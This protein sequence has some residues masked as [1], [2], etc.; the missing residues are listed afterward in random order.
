M[1]SQSGQLLQPEPEPE[2]E[3]EP[4]PPQP[5]H[6][7]A[8]SL[9][10]RLAPA[11][12]G[13]T[14]DEGTPPLRPADVQR[15]F[16]ALVGEPFDF[17]SPYEIRDAE[18]ERLRE[19][20]VAM[21][22]STGAS[23]RR[24]LESVQHLAS[25][26][27]HVD[28]M[29]NLHYMCEA[30]IVQA[31]V[32]LCDEQHRRGSDDAL[33]T[34]A[35][36]CLSALGRHSM[37]R[38]ALRWLMR[39][40][41]RSDSDFT[42]DHRQGASLLLL[43]LREVVE[44]DGPATFVDLRDPLPTS[45]RAGGGKSEGA[46]AAPGGVRMAPLDGTW[47]T[48]GYSVL[49]WMR[50]EE[51]TQDAV[52]PRAVVRFCSTDGTTGWALRM[53]ERRL[54]L[55]FTAST[56]GSR[57]KKAMQTLEL[58]H[59][60]MP[61]GEWLHVALV[62]RRHKL[63]KST[64][65]LYVN[66]ELQIAGAAG[67]AGGSA[68][69]VSGSSSDDGGM[70]MPY[71]EVAG[72][73]TQCHIGNLKA[74]GNRWDVPMSFCGQLGPVIL[75]G[76]EGFDHQAKAAL[77]AELYQ[78]G[79]DSFLWLD[80]A[81]SRCDFTLPEGSRRASQ[82]L[83]LDVCHAFIP[84]A[85]L[86]MDLEESTSSSS[87]STTELA[88]I[89]NSA[90]V[91]RAS[92]HN[93]GDD[94]PSG[95]GLLRPSLSPEDHRRSL[96][97]RACF[98][99]SSAFKLSLG[100]L[101]GP[102]LVIPF[103]GTHQSEQDVSLLFRLLVELFV[104]DETYRQ[105]MLGCQ[106]FTM[107]A[108]LLSQTHLVHL[109]A[110]V[111]D[112]IRAVSDALPA[113]S[114]PWADLQLHLIWHFPLWVYAPEEYQTKL[115]ELLSRWTSDELGA[116][117]FR[118]LI[119][120]QRILDMIRL[121]YWDEHNPGIR[122]RMPEERKLP[123]SVLSIYLTAS[124]RAARTSGRVNVRPSR[125]VLA[126]MR[127]RL[128]C[129]V[130]NIVGTTP[131]F[132]EVQA[133]VSFAM[134][135]PDPIPVFE[136]VEMIIRLYT[137]PA[138]TA[139]MVS[140]IE[141][142][143]GA[144]LCLSGFD[145][146]HPVVDAAFMRL[147]SV[148]LTTAPSKKVKP[149]DIE[150]LMLAATSQIEGRPQAE[151]AIDVMIQLLFLQVSSPS[152]VYSDY[153]S[154]TSGKLRF[155]R[156]FLTDRPTIRFPAL[157]DCVLRA[158]ALCEDGVR[159]R[160]VL[161]LTRIIIDDGFC[162]LMNK[163]G[164]QQSLIEVACS[165]R[166]A[167]AS[168]DNQS[169]VATITAV[170]HLFRKALL[171]SF[172]DDDGHKVWQE[173]L[174]LIRQA[175]AN[176]QMC[177]VL[178][179]QQIIY[180]GMLVNLQSE[181]GTATVKSEQD[182]DALWENVSHF[183]A[184]EEDWY[185]LGGSVGAASAF[186]TE[187]DLLSCDFVDLYS[188]FLFAV[189]DKFRAAISCLDLP[190][191]SHGGQTLFDVLLAQMLT[192]FRHKPSADMLMSIIPLF[193]LNLPQSSCMTPRRLIFAVVQLLDCLQ[194]AKSDVDLQDWKEAL[195]Q[196]IAD[197][198]Q[199]RWDELVDDSGE[200]LLGDQTV[201][202]PR[203]AS[204]EVDEF[205]TLLFGESW[206][207]HLDQMRRLAQE[208]KAT[209]T[210]RTE[211]QVSRIFGAAAVSALEEQVGKHRIEESSTSNSLITASRSISKKLDRDETNR[212]TA[213][214][215][216]IHQRK[217]A[218]AHHLLVDLLHELCTGPGAYAPSE[219]SSHTTER[220]QLRWKID[221][222][223]LNRG[224]R[225]RMRLCH[226]ANGR[227]YRTD[228]DS[229]Q[230]QT[231][232]AGS[233]INTGTSPV[234]TPQPMDLTA[235]ESSTTDVESSMSDD[236]CSAFLREADKH[237]SHA[238]VVQPDRFGAGE[239]SIAQE[240]DEVWENQRSGFSSGF[241]HEHLLPVERGPWTDGRGLRQLPKDDWDCVEG[242]E[243]ATEWMV[244]HSDKN[245]EDGWSY[246]QSF[247]APRGWRQSRSRMSRVRRR[248]WVRLRKRIG[249]GQ[250]LG[251]VRYSGRSSATSARVSQ[252]ELQSVLTEQLFEAAKTSVGSSAE[253]A[254][255]EILGLASALEFDT[256]MLHESL[257][258]FDNDPAQTASYLQELADKKRE[259][260]RLERRGSIQPE[261]AA[262]ASLDD[263]IK[264]SLVA[265]LTELLH[266][267]HGGSTDEEQD[268][269]RQ[270]VKQQFGLG[271][272]QI[273]ECMSYM[274]HIFGQQTDLATATSR[275]SHISQQHPSEAAS[276]GA[277]DLVQDEEWDNQVSNADLSVLQ[278][279][280]DDSQAYNEE[281]PEIVFGC[282]W[283]TPTKEVMGS[284]S[285]TGR[286][287]YFSPFDLNEEK[288]QRW[289][290]SSLQLMNRRRYLM[291]HTALEF[292]LSDGTNALLD[293]PMPGDNIQ[294]SE[295]IRAKKPP[296]LDRKACTFSS[297]DVARRVRELSGQW[298]AGNIDNFNYLMALN[299]LAGR[300]YSDLTQYPVMPWVLA[301]YTSQ[302]LDLSNPE[303]FRDLS[304]PM[305][306]LSSERL[307]K[308][309]QRADS[310]EDDS[311]P[312]FLFGT[313]YS[314]KAAT[315]HYLVRLEPFTSMHVR[316]QSGKFDSADRMFHSIPMT[317]DSCTS[318]EN[319]S[320]VKE[321][322]PEWFYCPEMFR[323]DANLPLGTRSDGAALADVI[324]PPWADTPEDFVRMHREALESPH[325]SSQLHNWIDLIFGVKQNGEAAKA[326]DNV[327]FHLTYE[328]AVTVDPMGGMD[329]IQQEA[330]KT[331]LSSFGQTPTQLFQKPHLQ[332]RPHSPLPPLQLVPGD[333]IPLPLA[334]KTDPLPAVVA[335]GTVSERDEDILYTLH[336][337]NEL[338][339]VRVPVVTS[340]MGGSSSSRGDK[341][342][343]QLSVFR[344]RLPLAGDRQRWVVPSPRTAAFAHDCR[345]LLLGCAWDCSL[346]IFRVSRSADSV[347]LAS[348]VYHRSAISCIGLSE[349]EEVLLLGSRDSNVTQWRLRMPSSSAGGGS[350]SGGGSSGGG[351]G[352]SSG[353][354][355]SLS[356][357]SSSSSSSSTGG[358]GSLGLERP[359]FVYSEHS[360]EVTAVACNV[361]LD[362]IASAS[363]DGMI[364]LR[365][366]RTGNYIRTI[367]HDQHSPQALHVPT[368]AS[369]AAGGADG[370]F[371]EPVYSCSFTELAITAKNGSIIS[372]FE[373]CYPGGVESE[374]LLHS[375]NGR[376]LHRVAVDAPSS[377]PVRLNGAAAGG[378]G[379]LAWAAGRLT[380]LLLCIEGSEIVVR[381][382][383]E[384]PL[385]DLVRFQAQ[386]QPAAAAASGG[387]VGGTNGPSG[388]VGVSVAVADGG[389]V[390]VGLS[391]GTVLRQTLNGIIPRILRRRAA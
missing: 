176:D 252:A 46:A 387:I 277:A 376:L 84:Q 367:K 16:D 309:R 220:D 115:L 103:F 7:P 239:D 200:P 256:T 11:A 229:T 190:A 227:S 123:S 154:I 129:V 109:G 78:Q 97:G 128:L 235:G 30:G 238:L 326:A 9:S 42:P 21:A 145:R 349:R 94:S 302:S 24:I 258:A 121:C 298:E 62:H 108:Q 15:L 1:D 150:A 370:S 345:L 265:S 172:Q 170:A 164:W 293:F 5:E 12:G 137:S 374:L 50:L 47:P 132:L 173:T 101:G 269:C 224:S 125:P 210:F 279:T 365:S 141:K 319:L 6:T 230:E 352:G 58:S 201:M 185:A 136:V 276:D 70:P 152:D 174:V 192:A 257:A 193:Q 33:A 333:G 202:L 331:Q 162:A 191:L 281:V 118:K 268:T 31:L 342:R 27:N 19:L 104:S 38:D 183:L 248:R 151:A 112:S 353:G 356:S 99:Q 274:A 263:S 254:V 29:R 386:T 364:V 43:V 297:Q 295:L 134:E 48:D 73:I 231:L 300:T 36:A 214:L 23:L 130:E 138:T 10:L 225:M 127:H 89:R 68:A 189:A 160:A 253:D 80:P 77:L 140:Y 335:I 301:D 53:I 59:W 65:S 337:S 66:G 226:N 204:A 259:S 328:G 339:I 233:P 139:L 156:E 209:G 55:S 17:R 155:S 363:A 74:P 280:R 13:G 282:Q 25:G 381:D 119:G 355:V 205:C 384:R 343:Q 110:K 289:P 375:I 113:D 54:H 243:W 272:E 96:I 181:I 20:P 242:W 244:E 131:S 45:Q 60:T 44:K 234:V 158:A 310:L 308:F 334:K 57:G 359:E 292:F 64:V 102:R 305:G 303:T 4:R 195:V 250:E 291:Q 215:P 390:Y 85:Y 208:T 18:R 180:R 369:A 324:L 322:T 14:L 216:R 117:R 325:V 135:C 81:E 56:M 312:W 251:P 270:A 388:V 262:L 347:L 283:I 236:F 321:L 206:K 49:L 197:V 120:V 22:Q 323:N 126:Q 313:H 95:R 149:A 169:I 203:A 286:A 187:A 67:I 194:S 290:F 275:E 327:F 373:S 63:R 296:N 61:V 218:K 287:M 264:S 366:V 219:V 382:L 358:Y 246:A 288:E 368:T 284:F 307:E 237:T 389:H 318:A 315:L 188:G 249:S 90:V 299:T 28:H 228:S 93:L 383:H 330:I 8:P 240:V 41:V 314:T 186:A 51:P 114:L 357:S 142:L 184:D 86:M 207:P 316:M 165:P 377:Q 122:M 178:P 247:P 222:T 336:A 285:L 157:L 105:T 348:I 329:P 40:V 260:V 362:T 143:G 88:Q 82:L 148:I 221:P 107:I 171:F 379:A 32:T 76:G 182:V 372:V 52:A 344:Q 111:V 378:G 106:A 317:W 255:A 161:D 380:E 75:C 212:V 147:L 320:N 304:K 340:S 361:D 223:E 294:V 133:M 354:G 213:E 245:D 26:N 306:A 179:F 35:L 39:L 338:R 341:K 167:G 153:E 198:L 351:G 211:E 350:G 332:R 3:L 177:F 163:S 146:Q 71:P 266:L 261:P 92:G 271:D 87:E 100:C 273:D 69:S 98:L 83:P 2:P 311:V 79:P 385:H 241:S 371:G 159:K 217:S 346:K 91:I 37:D 196:A 267:Q 166:P 360:A 34:K 232:E 199:R 116:S 175:D 144:Q 168:T 124:G 278:E 391:D 72:P